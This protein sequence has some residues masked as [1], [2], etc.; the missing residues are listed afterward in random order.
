[1]LHSG[2][3]GTPTSPPPKDWWWTHALLRRLGDG[4]LLLWPKL[5]EQGTVLQPGVVNLQ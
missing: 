1:M 2:L 5:Q 3:V 4:G